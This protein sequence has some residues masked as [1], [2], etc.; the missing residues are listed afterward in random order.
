VDRASGAAS[1]TQTYAVTAY[2]AFANESSHSNAATPS[3]TIQITDDNG[4][5]IAASSSAASVYGQ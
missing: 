4:E 5:V 3:D 1:T 2:D